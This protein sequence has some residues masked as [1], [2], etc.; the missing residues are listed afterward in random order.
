GAEA[1]LEGGELAYRV[2]GLLAPPA[3][4]GAREVIAVEPQRLLEVIRRLIDIILAP[5]GLRGRAD[6]RVAREEVMG[7]QA[8]VRRGDALARRA[9]LEGGVEIAPRAGFI[10]HRALGAGR[11]RREDGGEEA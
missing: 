7:L 8:R 10:V 4:L 1:R 3:L 6:E 11:G 9:G 5:I 2:R